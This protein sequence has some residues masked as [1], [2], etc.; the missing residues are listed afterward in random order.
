MKKTLLPLNLQ[1]FADGEVSENNQEVAELEGTTA[2]EENSEVETVEQTETNEQV[3]SAEEN[4]R[5]AAARRRAEQEFAERQRQEDAEYERR[6]GNYEN[7]IT[8]QPIRSRKDYFDALDAQEKLQRNQELE[9]KGIDPKVFEDMVNKEVANNPMILQAQELIAQQKKTAFDN[10]L[11][12]DIKAIQKLDPSIKSVDDIFALDN[13][14]QI[15]ALTKDLSLADA[16]KLANFD[17]LMSN[18][19]S[20]T[21]QAAINSIK[22]T[23]HLNSTTGLNTPDD[24]EVEIPESELGAWKRAFPDASMSELKKKYNRSL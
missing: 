13:A 18:K 11:A 12:E 7:P 4:A 15:I 17:A 10:Q 14:D 16:Y 2:T 21:K 6:F 20:A 24:G 22:G 1:F 5:Y 9:S 3:Q 19:T 23:Q 8:H